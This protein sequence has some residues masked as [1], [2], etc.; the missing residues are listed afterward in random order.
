MAEQKNVAHICPC[1]G[2]EI[3]GAPNA[4]MC[5][6]CLEEHVHELSQLRN[7]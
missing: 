1:C 7:S 4:C 2:I 3:Y 6:S 5:L